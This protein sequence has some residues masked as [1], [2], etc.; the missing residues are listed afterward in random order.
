MVYKIPKISTKVYV[1]ILY[2][3]VFSVFI[4]AA[5]YIIMIAKGY[6]FDFKNR[7]IRKTGMI[8][9]V[10]RPSGADIYLNDKKLSK[11]TGFS[12]FPAKI[13]NLDPGKYKVLVKKEGYKDWQKTIEVKEELVS[14][15]NYILLI[16]EKPTKKE[17]IKNID[18]SNISISPNKRKIAY[19]IKN[20]NLSILDI[21]SEE[22]ELLK[23]PQIQNETE[24]LNLDW[25]LDSTRLLLTIK[26]VDKTNYLV[27]NTND[28][29]DFSLISDEYSNLSWSKNNSKELFAL[30]NKS[31]YKIDVGEV[32]N[33]ALL[34][35]NIIS[36]T[37][38]SGK[39][40]F[41]AYSEK[42]NSLF[43][44]DLN[45]EN[46]EEISDLPYSESY[47][48]SYSKKLDG[49]AV[50]VER[51]QNLFYIY[52]FGN[53]T[54]TRKMGQNIKDSLWSNE[55]KQLLYWG[56]DFAFVYNFDQENEKE[57]PLFSGQKINYLHWYFDEYHLVL[58]SENK[59]K[60]LEFDGGNITEMSSIVTTSKV[61]YLEDYKTFF[62]LDKSKD[63]ET[64][65]L[66]ALKLDPEEEKTTT[67]KSLLG[68]IISWF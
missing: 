52:K 28:L 18:I 59:L 60:I 11:K 30:K 26:N 51:T 56:E 9:L 23:I 55:G 27:I 4:G 37:F 22:S 54:I 48:L 32:L 21:Q 17:S 61:E 14:W 19:I 64:I 24:I 31:L 65:S 41:A 35:E 68:R 39:I 67:R 40:I 66:Y 62:Y 45:G 53:Q 8:I 43:S 6:R 12:L 46:K 38:T 7:S 58:S 63:S 1:F 42:Q 3:L 44:M 33:P 50:V 34:S 15:A 13:S 20:N 36:Y 57:Y 29:N 25:N 5:L 47:K 2:V 49:T 16:P 10:S